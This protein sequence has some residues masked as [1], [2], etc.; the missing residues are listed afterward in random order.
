MI[1]LFNFF[2]LNFNIVAN[3]LQ[4]VVTLSYTEPCTATYMCQTQYNLLC[5]TTANACN[6]PTTSAVG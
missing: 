3:I 5:Q 6:C 2:N 4:C 1:D